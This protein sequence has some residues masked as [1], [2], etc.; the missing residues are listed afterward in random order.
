MPKLPQKA[1][2]GDQPVRVENPLVVMFEGPE[3]KV[4]TRIHAPPGYSHKMFGLLVC[5]LVRHIAGAF[6]VSEADVWEWVD[7]ERK[8]PTTDITRPS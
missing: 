4:V 5:D 7:K 8:R 3:K 2:P 1:G 6:K